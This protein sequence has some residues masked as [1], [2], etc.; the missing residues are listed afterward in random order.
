M[1]VCFIKLL[2]QSQTCILSIKCRDFFHVQIMASELNIDKPLKFSYF[3][4]EKRIISG[5]KISTQ[6]LTFSENEYPKDYK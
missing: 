2:K 1:C 5:M 3:K 4:F 6:I